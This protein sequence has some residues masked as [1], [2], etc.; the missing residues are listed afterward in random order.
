MSAVTVT[1]LRTVSRARWLFS[2]ALAAGGFLAAAG[3]TFAFSLEAAEGSG[4]S[5]VALWATSVATWLPVFAAFLGMDVWSDERLTGRIDMLLSAAVRERDYVL[6]KFLGVWS[7][8]LAATVFFL[9]SSMVFLWLFAPSALA[10]A[11]VTDFLPALA[12]LALQSA[13]WCSVSVAVSVFFCHGAAAAFTSVMLTSVLPR[14]IWKGLLAW[15]KD[16]R[17]AFGEMPFDAHVVD[18]ASGVVPLCT[19]AGYVVATAVF[20]FV[21]SVSVG[22]L[23]LVGRG[24][25]GKRLVARVSILLALV[26]G[27][28][29][30]NLV[31]RLD[32]SIDV[33]PSGSAAA[34]SSRTRA[35]L[36]ESSGTIRATCFLPRSDVRFRFV[37]H[38]LTSLKRASA[39]VGGA[40]FDIRYVDPRW[41]IGAAER[42]V[43]SGVDPDSVVF[44]AG[45]RMV[46]LPLSDGIGER[47]CAATVRRLTVPSSR[48]SIFWTVGHGETSFSSY[49][50]FGMSD[51]ARDL[52]REGFSHK[53]ID[54]AKTRQ[55]P[56]DCALVLVAGAADDFA[57]SELDVLDAYL[58]AGG[59]LLVLM[60]SAQVNGLASLLSAWGLRPQERSVASPK[61]ISGTDVIVTGFADHPVS[62]SL[63]G[64]RVVFERPV[65]FA[66]SAVAGKGAGAD[67]IGYSAIAHVDDVAF[68]A[69]VER[70]EGAGKDIAVRPT[71]IIAVGDAG[72]VLNGQLAARANA[73]C[74]FFLNCISY[75]AGTDPPGADGAEVGVLVTG[76]DRSTRLMHIVGSAVAL[77][78]AVFLVLA[79]AAA[80]RRRRQ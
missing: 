68:A 58:R 75:L 34:F 70:G 13:L 32:F 39:A 15:S 29:S 73:N 67:A 63:K 47:V 76:M 7:L 65:S 69:A 19:C 6:G 79:F 74:D 33:S 31:S 27:A 71:R 56:D 12:M 20:L 24:A 59:R 45:R 57:R 36:A 64:L 2:N 43:R 61:T 46:A 53:T 16:G 49:D 80:R 44:E 1:C 9:V 50:T 4:L 38:I 26:F 23:R 52:M 62:S 21:A 35:I 54:L 8:S 66:P 48:R 51:V 11:D 72:F 22:N 18:C 41:D 5:V 30:V 60:S 14:G 28:L 42:L 37:A 3:V 78:A 10:S 25:A 40:R 55:V 77:P 17:T